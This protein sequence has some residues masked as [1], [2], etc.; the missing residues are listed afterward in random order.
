MKNG[1]TIRISINR[2]LN[3]AWYSF[4][5]KMIRSERAL[6]RKTYSQRKAEAKK[7]IA[8]ANMKLLLDLNE[9]IPACTE[10]DE[11]VSETESDFTA[12]MLSYTSPVW[13][14]PG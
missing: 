1:V 8:D 7:K 13:E 11:D 6:A 14:G 3:L 5:E 2:L 12:N 4:G 9:V 10:E